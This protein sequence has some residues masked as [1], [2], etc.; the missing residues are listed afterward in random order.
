MKRRQLARHL[1]LALLMPLASGCAGLLGADDPGDATSTPEQTATSTP[2]AAAT[3]TATPTRTPTATPE[4]TPE[5]QTTAPAGTMP[6]G[7]SSSTGLS[8]GGDPLTVTSAQIR[9][10]GRLSVTVHNPT[11][12]AVE[13]DSYT[14]N[15]ASTNGNF[16]LAPGEYRDLG[17]GSVADAESIAEADIS[18]SIVARR[19]GASDWSTVSC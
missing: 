18:V 8:C 1:S 15:D 17:G 4:P 12:D 16:L 19:R 7:A 3:P 11:S 9:G 13:V 5:S 14:I 6:A 10:A 2:T